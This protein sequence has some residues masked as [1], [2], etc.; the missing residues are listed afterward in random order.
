MRSR[1]SS[2]NVV[3]LATAAAVGP[4]IKAVRGL[5]FAALPWRLSDE[6]LEIL[7]LTSR[8]SRR[9]IIPKG[10][11]IEGLSPPASAA[12]EAFE[13]SGAV[14]KVSFEQLGSYHYFKRLKNNITVPCKVDVYPLEVVRMRRDWP[15]KDQRTLRWCIPQEAAASVA[16]SDLKLLI[17]KFARLHHGAGTTSGGK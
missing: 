14:G 2:T 5:Q 4:H 6:R 12:Q 16:E 15:E 8:E 13:E 17:R 10:W 7:L 9:W 11:P 3:P 1:A